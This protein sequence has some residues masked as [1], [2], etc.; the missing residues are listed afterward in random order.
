MTPYL[1]GVDPGL[2]S[3]GLALLQLDPLRPVE[4]AVLRTRPSPRKRSVLAAEDSMRRAREL[5][6]H[7]APWLDRPGLVAVASEGQSWPRRPP[8]GR[9]GTPRPGPHPAPPS[10]SWPSRG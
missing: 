5:A 6:E 2:A 8:R 7:L 9:R 10:P 4:L 1:L 3:C